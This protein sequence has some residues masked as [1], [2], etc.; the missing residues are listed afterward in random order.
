MWE[1]FPRFF[2][3]LPRHVGI[4]R[5][6]AEKDH[7]RMVDSMRNGTAAFRDLEE[8]GSIGRERQ[9]LANGTYKVLATLQ[10]G[11]QSYRVAGELQ[12]HGETAQ[13][14]THRF[15][16]PNQDEWLADRKIVLPLAY[17]EVAPA[18]RPARDFDFVLCDPVA[19]DEATAATLFGPTG[20]PAT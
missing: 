12:V 6:P 15:H 20:P 10:C 17:P 11:E 3:V 14:R 16:V 18:E 7:S 19:L 5:P 9:P 13:L 8:S 4:A 1:S 2:R